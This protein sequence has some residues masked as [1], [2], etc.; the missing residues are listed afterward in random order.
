MEL[1]IFFAL[2]NSSL[3]VR[4]NTSSN[5]SIFYAVFIFIDLASGLSF[6]DIFEEK[7]LFFYLFL[8]IIF[9]QKFI[10]LSI[11]YKNII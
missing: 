9:F 1:C 11:F 6:F 8:K 4:T 7:F 5:P 3:L 10:S 2:S